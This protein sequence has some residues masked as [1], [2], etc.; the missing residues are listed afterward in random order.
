M[1]YRQSNPTPPAPAPATRRGFTLAE[2]LVAVSV[3]IVLTLAIGQV[4]SA[5]GRLVSTGSAVSEV[6]QL[7]RA[8]ERQLREDFASISRMDPAETFFAIRSRVAGDGNGDGAVTALQ[9]ERA[10]YLTQE[11]KDADLRDGHTPYQ[12]NGGT[13][14]GRAV[15]TRLDEMIFLARAPER[16]RYSSAQTFGMEGEPVSSDVARIYYGHGL[17]PIAPRAVGGNDFDPTAQITTT[18]RPIRR[19]SPDMRDAPIITDPA[20]DASSVEVQQDLDW[21]SAFGAPLSRNE[22]AS[23]FTLLRQP[24]LLYGGR[25][26]GGAPN[27]T[28]PRIATINP[29]SWFPLRSYAPFIRDRETQIRNGLGA[30]RYA[31]SVFAPQVGGWYYPTQANDVP[32]PTG[33]SARL[34]RWGR[35]DICAQDRDDVQR[36]L[37]GV[38]TS[39]LRDTTDPLYDPPDA[40][41]FTAGTLVFPET[42]DQLPFEYK[43]P[44]PFNGGANAS[45]FFRI[46]P[47]W[48][49]SGIGLSANQ[50]V[51]LASTNL[52]SAIA[53]VFTR[54]LCEPG[55]GAVPIRITDAVRVGNSTTTRGLPV[56][57]R[58][59]PFPGE[60]T[61][62]QHA[63]L[64]GRC[65]RFEIAWSDGTRWNYPEPLKVYAGAAA[66]P[67]N[68]IAQIN[69]GDLVW[70]DARF[71]QRQYRTIANIPGVN[72]GIDTNPRT[73]I[74]DAEVI[75]NRNDSAFF[76]TTG[77]G[78]NSTA[79]VSAQ[80][81]GSV[82]IDQQRIL[83]VDAYSTAPADNGRYDFRRSGG[84]EFEYMAIWGFR[85]PAVS[86]EGVVP[87]LTWSEKPW[88]KPR[89]VRVRMTLHDGQDKLA[90]GKDFEYVL[91]IDQK[92]E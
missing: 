64:A 2:L 53:G 25:A 37:E 79:P 49:P 23:E 31:Y 28:S 36:W 41:P 21:G 5:V 17:K 58:P 75:P 47:Q 26:A 27:P 84:D 24:L 68:L 3:V 91:A 62:D 87:V 54:M 12:R 66:T 90:A 11:D 88:T 70:F 7:A 1:T 42:D 82:A 32:G 15:T 13:K 44:P 14:V 76:A 56:I 38:E 29:S 20:L 59:D 18:N 85:R 40:R 52:R 83:V 71:T 48:G 72:V 92:Q 10:I 8:I 77:G 19:L 57:D 45:L 81:R 86:D 67:E 61:M 50:A 55:P 6:D 30:A 51:Q 35:T 16:T 22:F 65:S 4:F 60:A 39:Y 9:G 63:V 74:P 43:F 80:D 69:Q 34:L 73:A 33:A 46:P 78:I 89:F